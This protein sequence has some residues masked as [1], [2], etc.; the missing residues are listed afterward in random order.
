MTTS[1]IE[2]SKRLQRSLDSNYNVS[3]DLCV[4]LWPQ[5]VDD[6][7]PGPNTPPLRVLASVPS[8][9]VVLLGQD[10]QVKVPSGHVIRKWPPFLNLPF[11]LPSLV[12]LICVEPSSTVISF[13]Q[14]ID[15]VAVFEIIRILEG[16]PIT[17]EQL[18]VSAPRR[19]L[20]LLQ[21]VV[22]SAI[23]ESL[24]ISFD[25]DGPPF[26]Y[27][28]KFILLLSLTPT[29]SQGPI[30][31]HRLS[32]SLALQ[33]TRLAKYI[34]QLRRKTTNEQLARQAKNLLKK[35]RDNLMPAIASG[36]PVAAQPPA[37]TAAA[38]APQLTNGLTSLGQVRSQPT[39]PSR[40]AVIAP[41]STNNANHLINNSSTT[42]T[43]QVITIPDEDDNE[44][45]S[46][47]SSNQTASRRFGGSNSNFIRDERST[48]LSI[49]SELTNFYL[50]NKKIIDGSS[51]QPLVKEE[52]PPPSLNHNNHHHYNNSS[53]PEADSVDNVVEERQ[54][55][56]KR[57]GRKK[58]SKGVDSTLGSS[59]HTLLFNSNSNSGFGD[60]N[61]ATAT[62]TSSSTVGKKVKTT[63]QL[64]ADLKFRNEQSLRNNAS[65]AEL[66]GDN[67]NHSNLSSPMSASNDSHHM[68]HHHGHNQHPISHNHE[69]FHSAPVTPSMSMVKREPGATEED[70]L[71]ARKREKKRR[72]LEKERATAA[73]RL[74]R[75]KIKREK[76]EWLSD[77]VCVSFAPSLYPCL[78]LDSSSTA[79][80][81]N[82]LPEPGGRGHL[83]AEEPHAADRPEGD[84]ARDEGGENSTGTG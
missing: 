38:V 84:S 49:P 61:S 26:V 39:T 71:S 59:M 13:F 50:K 37:A 46:Q 22:I 40:P 79:R 19:S 82:E 51:A 2:L 27:F 21:V 53:Y 58:G 29:Y 76:S 15:L 18:E 33:T 43:D 52:N 24:A 69:M 41:T 12:L 70:S 81:R 72:K 42:S 35:W 54:Q 34:N 32:I 14:V 65:Y 64:V 45:K 83:A 48:G 62:G 74:M 67:N 57:R 3:T 5:N 25:S 75:A 17:T 30:N 10:R 9:T 77:C 11:S 63:R 16:T 4:C 68:F 60:N 66:S 23:V 44:S 8:D 28:Y 6:N 80:V 56:Q 47:G 20:S 7:C 31:E 55:Q 36:A 1:V 73:D 78:L